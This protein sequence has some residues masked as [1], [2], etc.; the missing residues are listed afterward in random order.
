MKKVLITGGAGFVGR[1]LA[2]HLLTRGDVEVTVI[3]NESLGDRKHL[4][5]DR[6]RFIQGDLR[7][8]DDLRGALEGQ[9]AVVHLAADPRVMDSIEN[10]VHNFENNVVG[11]FNLLELCRELGVNRVVAAS[12]GGAIL[13]DVEPP[14]HERMAPQPT[15]PYGASKLMLEGYLSAYSSSFGVSGCALRFSNIYGSRSF[16]KGSVV[17]HFYKQILAGDPLIVYGDGSQTRDFLFAG[18]L[19]EAIRTAVDSDA[20]GAFQLG[21]GVGTTVNQL[22]DHMRD[23]TGLD[24]EVVYQDFRDGEIKDTWCD[25]TK[26]REGFGFAPTTPLADGLKQTW[27][28]FTTAS[29]EGRNG[30]G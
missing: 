26:A 14:V 7:N 15:S 19:V 9:D 11:T 12:T 29:R 25:I 2:D 22:I 21:S 10:P 30:A 20:E 13:G 17:A 23:A 18:D 8:R 27:D 16:H 24:L 1:H 28:W 4:D 5:L 6:V 3:D